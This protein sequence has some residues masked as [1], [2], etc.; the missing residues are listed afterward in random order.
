LDDEYLTRMSLLLDVDGT[1]LDI[2]PTPREVVVPRELPKMLSRVRDRLEGA[3][4]LVSGR[5]IAELDE[6]F[7]PL[8]LVAIGGHGAEMRPVAA[9]PV[10]AGRAEPID[11]E[12]KERIKAIAERHPGVLVEDKGYSLALHYRQAPRQGVGLIHDV[13]HAHEAWGDNSIELLTGKAV[14]E[15]K[16]AGFN[17]GSAVRQLMT[18]PP[19]AGRRP[20]FIGD[21]QTDE[22]AFRAMPDFDGLSMSVGRKLPGIDKLFGSPADVRKWLGL[23]SAAEAVC[24]TAHEPV[25]GVSV[26]HPESGAPYA[27]PATSEDD[28]WLGS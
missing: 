1:L 26:M 5:T 14:L 20:V 28:G 2:A 8:Q 17:K 24:P 15:L 18:Y 4:A 9:G 13:K 12:F 19:F 3:L 21:D 6:F 22:D 23:L 11:T 10:I 27:M 25:G 16:F 7:A